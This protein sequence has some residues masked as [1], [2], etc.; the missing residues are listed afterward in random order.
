MGVLFI[1]LQSHVK[2]SPGLNKVHNVII[3]HPDWLLNELLN[4]MTLVSC[5]AADKL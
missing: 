5:P 3:C 4:T 1:T 2:R